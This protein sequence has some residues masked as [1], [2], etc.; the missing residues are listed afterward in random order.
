MTAKMR[1]PVSSLVHFRLGGVGDRSKAPELYLYSPIEG[2][3]SLYDSRAS[4]LLESQR[5]SRHGRL[6]SKET[7]G[8]QDSIPAK[9]RGFQGGFVSQELYSLVSKGQ[10]LKNLRAL[11]SRAKEHK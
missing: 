5:L 11:R 6:A 10:R 8:R 7:L 2:A 4:V 9:L 3:P 1:R